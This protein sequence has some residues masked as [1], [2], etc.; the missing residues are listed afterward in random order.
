ML[1]GV[2]VAAHGSGKL[3]E[4]VVGAGLASAV[5]GVAVTGGFSLVMR[6]HGETLYCQSFKLLGSPK[7][8]SARQRMRYSP[9]GISPP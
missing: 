7:V 9:A 4:E 5:V 3:T 8:R 1:T 6:N 2:E